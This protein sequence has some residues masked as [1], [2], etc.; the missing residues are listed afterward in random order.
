[1]KLSVIFIFAL[2]LL[3]AC[4]GQTEGRKFWRKFGKKLE[5]VGQNVRKAAEKTLPIVQGYAGV[6]T[7]LG[8]GRH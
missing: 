2:I 4:T 7:Q 6:A 5:K 8:Y 3:V 1:M